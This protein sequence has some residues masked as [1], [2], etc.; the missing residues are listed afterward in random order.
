MA[1]L[2]RTVIIS[3]ASGSSGP[4]TFKYFKGNTFITERSSPS[5]PST[6]NQQAARSRFT[7]S[8]RAFRGFSASIVQQ[9][10]DY[11]QTTPE[12]DPITGASKFKDGINAYVALATKYLQA[13]PGGTPPTTPPAAPFVP[14]S[15]TVTALGA[16]GKV[17]FTASSALAAGTKCELLLEKLASANRKPQKNGYRS[18]AFAQFPV[19]TL[20]F[21][22]TVTPGNYAAAYRF[23]NTNTGQTS[24]LRSVCTKYRWQCNKAAARRPLERLVG[25][26]SESL[27][28][29]TLSHPTYGFYRCDRFRARISPVAAK[30]SIMSEHG[31]GTTLADEVN[32]AVYVSLS[33]PPI[34]FANEKANCS[35]TMSVGTLA[36]VNVTPSPA[37]SDAPS[38]ELAKKVPELNVAV[39]YG[40]LM[41]VV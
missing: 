29:P 21:D 32:D 1:K 31:S 37:S 5:N 22:V 41:S 16:T 7:A 14:P 4:V 30:P 8:T 20:S 39:M 24:Q 12:H 17:T 2:K 35:S 23:V 18:K 26:V 28:P 38:A 9:W 33:F 25:R 15:V 40:L 6:L 11:V 13:T 10:D 19:G 34:V 36:P 3:G 27:N